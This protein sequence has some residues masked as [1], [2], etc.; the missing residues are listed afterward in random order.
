MGWATASILVSSLP[1]HM[2]SRVF[3]VP[4]GTVN[5]TAHI[6]SFPTNLSIIVSAQGQSHIV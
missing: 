1:D 4:A 5:A 3:L 2:C 6:V